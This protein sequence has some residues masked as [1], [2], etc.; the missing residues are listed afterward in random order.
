MVINHLLVS[1][2]KEGLIK[3]YLIW[4]QYLPRL[5]NQKFVTTYVTVSCHAQIEHLQ[6]P[7]R[8]L[9]FGPLLVV[10]MHISPASVRS[11]PWHIFSFSVQFLMRG[12]PEPANATRPISAALTWKAIFRPRR[13][14]LENYDISW[15]NDCF[16]RKKTP[17]NSIQVNPRLCYFFWDRSDRPGLTALHHAL[18]LEIEAP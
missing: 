12:R 11:E 10:L 16:K 4:Y 9:S 2:Q 15:R 17:Q 13:K 8:A 3:P 7:R 5:L 18:Q 1:Q 6:R 14:Y